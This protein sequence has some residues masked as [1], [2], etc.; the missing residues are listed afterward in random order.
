MNNANSP[1]TSGKQIVRPILS[2]DAREDRALWNF[3]LVLLEIAE[4]R[5][6]NAIKT[7]AQN[8]FDIEG[9]VYG[10]TDR[11]SSVHRDC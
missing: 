7:G 1:H 4:K 11:D 10:K 5:Q 6:S 9:R 8:Q 3:S 2:G